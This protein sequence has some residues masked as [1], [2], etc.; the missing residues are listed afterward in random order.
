MHRHKCR[1]NI[2]THKIKFKNKV[3]IWK[4]KKKCSRLPELVSRENTTTSK[5]AE[6]EFIRSTVVVMYMHMH[7]F[8]VIRWAAKPN[9]TKPLDV[10]WH[11]KDAIHAIV[12]LN[13]YT[14]PPGLMRSAPAQHA[15]LLS[16]HSWCDV[17]PTELTVFL[18]L[19]NSKAQNSYSLACTEKAWRPPLQSK[20]GL[21]K[22]VL[23]NTDM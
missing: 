18:R 3:K 2:N 9:Q 6:S 1:Q 11:S 19:V 4:K 5:D 13:Q 10:S 8:V 7:A 22:Y 15:S 17:T 12:N 20:G 14:V 16:L 23:R 21:L